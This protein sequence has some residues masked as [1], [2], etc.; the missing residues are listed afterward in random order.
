MPLC[1]QPSLAVVAQFIL[2][3]TMF[4]RWLY[5]IGTNMRAAIVSGVPTESV[6]VLTYM[7]SGFCAAVASVVVLLSHGYGPPYPGRAVLAGYHRRRGH[8]RLQSVGR[9]RQSVWTFFGVLFL[10]LLGNALSLLNVPFFWI[11]I[12]EGLGHLD[13]RLHRC[14]PHPHSCSTMLSEA[15]FHER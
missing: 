1:D 10:S 15:S 7:F 12:V 8:W 2:S 13:G 4:G 14:D 11:E 5:A 3:R 6:I 9:K